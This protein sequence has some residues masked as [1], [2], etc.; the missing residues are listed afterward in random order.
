MLLFLNTTLWLAA[1]LLFM[2]LEG[3]HEA[4]HKCGVKKVQRDF[5]DA[6]WQEAA[7]LEELEWKSAARQRI[8]TF[9]NQIHEAVAA[10]VSSTSGQHVWSIPNTFVYVFTLS[11][12]IGERKQGIYR[13]SGNIITCVRVQVTAT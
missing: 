11:T 12:T 2:Q 13:N 3:G 9:E 8:M 5:V 7:R 1:T 4:E 6:L 10:G